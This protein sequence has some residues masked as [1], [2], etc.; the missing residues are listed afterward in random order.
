MCGNT[1]FWFSQLIDVVQWFRPNK[2]GLCIDKVIGNRTRVVPIAATNSLAAN[3]IDSVI[4]FS[5]TL[6][7]SF[8]L[9]VFLIHIPWMHLKVV[10]TWVNWDTVIGDNILMRVESGPWKLLPVFL[11]ERPCTDAAAF[12]KEIQVNRMWLATLAG[13][14]VFFERSK[15]IG[16]NKCVRIF[17]NTSQGCLFFASYPNEGIFVRRFVK[18]GIRNTGRWVTKE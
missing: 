5:T 9:L 11:D 18:R 6:L 13:S 17:A 2:Q 3:R 10:L 12:L 8:G 7:Y 4:A 16:R 14:R 15:N 1:K